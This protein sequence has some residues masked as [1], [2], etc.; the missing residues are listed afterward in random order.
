MTRVALA[1]L[2]FSALPV[3]AYAKNPVPMPYDSLTFE[4][5]N[6]AKPDSPQV[7]VVQGDLKQ[8]ASAFYM[9]FK[10]GFHIL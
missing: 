7:A 9:K 1:L 8:T 10:P 4:G 2:A 5:M 3:P 6:P